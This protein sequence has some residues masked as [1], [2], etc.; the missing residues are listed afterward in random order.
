MRHG[1]CLSVSLEVAGISW[2]F[3]LVQYQSHQIRPGDQIGH[4][5]CVVARRSTLSCASRH[6]HGNSV[7][8]SRWMCSWQ[9]Q[10]GGSWGVWV[11]A[12]FETGIHKEVVPCTC[13]QDSPS[14][15]LLGSK[16]VD[17]V[18]L[19]CWLGKQR[20]PKKKN[21]VNFFPR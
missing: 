10:A 12:T 20:K 11:P 8:G 14:A 16:K 18:F 21:A 4:L 5:R 7:M 19:F 1:D 15:H 13:L 3:Q 2:T 17:R 9:W 6:S